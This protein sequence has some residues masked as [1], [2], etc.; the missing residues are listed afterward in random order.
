MFESFEL[1]QIKTSGATI[2]VARAGTGPP[3]LLLHG[4]PQTHVMWHKVAPLLC[5][6][7]HRRRHRSARVRRQQQAARAAPITP[8]YSK[9][10]MAQDQV[11]VM[12][13]LGFETVR[14]GGPRPRRPRGASH[15]ARSRRSR[16]EA[17]AARH[18]SHASPLHR[19]DARVRDRVFLVVLPHSARAA[20][21][22][23]DRQQ[24]RV[25]ARGEVRQGGA[26]AR[27]RARRSRNI[28]AATGSPRR[29][30]RAAKT[31]APPRRS[32]WCTTKR[33]WSGRSHVRCWRSGPSARRCTG[34]MTWRRRGR[35][36]RRTSPARR[37][38]A[39]TTSP[40]RFPELVAD[41]LRTFFG[42]RP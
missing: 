22:D 9:R 42:D 25:L 21:R 36:A 17:R 11:E 20:A 15:G 41:E 24:R 3:L 19:L 33:T 31:T 30:T 29:F 6:G 10:A 37:C 4:Y 32:I 8:A 39:R 2:A 1:T 27:S 16:H 5:E 14:R 35:S 23:D 40:K 13:R 38:R 28:C 7:L 26:R 34:S 12:S 18:R